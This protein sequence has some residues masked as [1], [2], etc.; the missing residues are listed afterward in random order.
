MRAWMS[1]GDILHFIIEQVAIDSGI[2][3]N[4]NTVREILKKSEMS[5]WAHLIERNPQEI[6]GVRPEF[7]EDIVRILRAAIGNL[8]NATPGILLTIEKIKDLESKGVNTASIIEAFSKVVSSGKYKVIGEDAAKEIINLSS[9]P[10]LAVIELLEVIGEYQDRSLKMNVN[11]Q[12]IEWDGAIPLSELFKG[13]IIPDDP[14]VCF[15]QRFLDY[16]ASNDEQ[17]D[18]I[19]WRNFERLCG[20]FFRRKGFVVKLGPGTRD[21]GID[22]RIWSGKKSLPTPP[23]IVMQ[24]KRYKKGK[25]VKIEYIKALWSDLKF[26]NAKRG[27]LATTSYIAPGGKKICTVRQWPLSFAENESVKKWTKGMWRFPPGVSKV[28][29]GVG[30]YLLPPVAPYLK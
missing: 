1:I 21:G 26:E 11:I 7:V 30:R 3:L 20:E 16:L 12:S 9:Q 22:I 8:P 4:S 28:S 29:K 25:E 2:L 23:L 13:E 15:D 24:C 19:H 6:F 18:K 10:P 14:Q 5:D 27:L 17:L